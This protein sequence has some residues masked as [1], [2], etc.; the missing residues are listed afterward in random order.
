V[1]RS[2]KLHLTFVQPGEFHL[3]YATGEIVMVTRQTMTIFDP[4]TQQQVFTQPVAA[5]FCPMA[6]AYAGGAG[7]LSQHLSFV[8]YPG[9]QMN[10]PGTEILVG[11]PTVPSNTTSKALFYA[12]PKTG[13]VIRTMIVT[14]TGDRQRFDAVKCTMNIP[15]PPPRLFAPPTPQPPPAPPSPGT[16]RPAIPPSPIVPPVTT[17]LP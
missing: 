11:T 16:P 12:D 13:E 10:A 5:N 2:S 6:F 8:S 17:S 7:S 3:L 14:P 1:T 9:A 15:P 4:K